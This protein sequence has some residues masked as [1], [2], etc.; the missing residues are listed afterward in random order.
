MRP[1]Q[2]IVSVTLRGLFGRRRFLLMVLLAALPILVGLAVRLGGGRS[3]AAEILDALV[4]R[5]VLPLIALV[6]GTAAIGTEIED[7]T[8]VYLLAKPIARWR[9]AAAKIAVA[10]GLGAALVVP[11]VLVTGLLIG[12]TGGDGPSLALG[13]TV[14]TLAGVIAYAAVFTALGAMT[15]RALVL[16]L[17]Y[18]LL[19]EGA[20]AG[21]L[22]GTKYFSIRE[23]TLGLAA[24]LTGSDAGADV[25]A[26]VASLGI[27]LIATVGAFALATLALVRF[28]IRSAD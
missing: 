6:V 23:A 26:P 7:G 13:F 8:A 24:A 27:V 20:L 2:A 15:S 1:L 14:A 28:E 19:W 9:I 22:E 5:I 18:T 10:I 4:I 11:P 12:G 16:G 25:L 3:D 17:T 21:L